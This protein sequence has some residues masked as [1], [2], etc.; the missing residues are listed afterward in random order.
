MKKKIN[1]QFQ[2]FSWP[3]LGLDFRALRLWW[4][5]FFFADFSASG[6]SISGFSTSGFFL[7]SGFLIPVDLADF[8]STLRLVG[9]FD[10]TLGQGKKRFSCNRD[11]SAARFCLLGLML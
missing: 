3:K 1:F 8:E 2:L 9:T 7:A 6:F 11:K 5:L 4:F 10:D